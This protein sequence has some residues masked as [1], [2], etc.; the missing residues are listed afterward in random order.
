MQDS[1]KTPKFIVG[2]TGGIGSGKSTV[3]KLFYDLGIQVVDA[4]IIARELVIPGSPCFQAIVDHFGHTVLEK[5]VAINAESAGTL[6]RTHL[7]ELIFSDDNEKSWLENL[8]H[9]AIREEIDRQIT[10]SD[11]A[12]IILSV[13]LL[14]ESGQ[15]DFVDRLLVVDIPEQIQVERIKARDASSEEL[16]REIM[17]SQISREPRRAAA[18]D[19]IDN[20]TSL[21]TLRQQVHDLHKQ[22]QQILNG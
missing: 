3:S 4:D 5:K 9:P 18:D 10:E 11:S 16:I 7:R 19:I 22:Y 6:N 20:S 15:Y 17:A 14:I 2:L 1:R 21:E 8:L 12:Y 13:P